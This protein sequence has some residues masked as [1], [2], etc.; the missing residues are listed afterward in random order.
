MSLTAGA[1]LVHSPLGE[2]GAHSVGTPALEDAAALDDEE[3]CGQRLTR[4]T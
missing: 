4:P 2:L 1:R 3:Q